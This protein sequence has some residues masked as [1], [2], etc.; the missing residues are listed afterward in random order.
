MVLL[1]EQDM[2][3]RIAGNTHFWWFEKS[4]YFVWKP[5]LFKD[6]WKN[7]KMW[8]ISWGLWSLSYYPEENFNSF[9]ENVN[10]KNTRRH[11]GRAY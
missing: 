4:C 11:Y 1:F 2:E 7:K 10:K 8:T 9:F 3:T 5:L 6:K